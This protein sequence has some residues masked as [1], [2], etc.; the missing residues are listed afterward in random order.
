M[1]TKDMDISQTVKIIL[2]FLIILMASPWIIELF[3]PS[4]SIYVSFLVDI[5]IS[6]MILHPL[7][8]HKTTNQP[9]IL[10]AD[11]L[12]EVRKDPLELRKQ[13][14][15]EKVVS[16]FTASAYLIVNACILVNSI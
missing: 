2:V 12:E 4:F 16:L 10:S 15:I 11:K 14:M 3:A 9:A 5:A 7:Y 8:V 13:I 6:L 1:I